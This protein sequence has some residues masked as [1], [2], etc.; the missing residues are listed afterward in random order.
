MVLLLCVVALA[1]D[2]PSIED[3]LAH[4]HIQKGVVLLLRQVCLAVLQTRDILRFFLF[5]LSSH[6]IFNI[7]HTDE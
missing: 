1:H 2:D 6:D 3:V 7:W 4:K 5:F